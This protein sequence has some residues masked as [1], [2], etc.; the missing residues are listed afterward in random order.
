M[1]D[2]EKIQDIRKKAE[3]IIA[4]KYLNNKKL[5]EEE[6]EYLINELSI[7]QIELELQNEELMKLHNELNEA[8]AN[9]YD[10][11]ENAPVGYIKLN[12]DL[13]IIE[14][15]MTFANF[16]NST[17]EALLGKEFSKFIAPESQDSF[18]FHYD[19]VKKNKNFKNITE[20]TVLSSNNKRITFQADSIAKTDVNGNLYIKTVLTDVSSLKTIE[21]QLKLERN[22]YETL[23]ETVPVGIFTL[24]LDN[25]IL[26]WNKSAEKITGYTKDEVI[27]KKCSLC[28]LDISVCDFWDEVNKKISTK[29]KPII[30]KQGELRQISFNYSVIKDENGNPYVGIN[31]LVDITENLKNQEAINLLQIALNTTADNII[32]FDLD[33]LNIITV[34]QAFINDLGYSEDEIKNLTVADI[35]HK[36][37]DELKAFLKENL[38][39]LNKVFYFNDYHYR[40]DGTSFPVEIQLKS[41]YN[42]GKLYGIAVARDISNRLEYQTKINEQQ[43]F[44]NTIVENLPVGVFAK[45]PNDDFKFTIWNKKMEQLFGISAKEAIGKTDFDFFD[46]NKANFYYESD[47][48]TINSKKPTVFPELYFYI[49]DNVF[50]GRAVKIAIFDENDNPT[51]ILGI[52]EDITAIK[53]NEKMLEESERKFRLIAENAKDIIY[54]VVIM[55]NE[56]KFDYVSPS[57]YEITGYTPEDIYENY[58]LGINLLTSYDLMYDSHLVLQDLENYFQKDTIFS[59][60][61]KNKKQIWLETR[62]SIF[63]KD[64]VIEIEGV[65]RDVSNFI[66][67][68][69]FNRSLSTIFEMIAQNEDIEN[70]MMK[71]VE[72][73][74]KFLDTVYCLIV[75]MGDK[76]NTF[77]YFNSGK[78]KIEAN[79]LIKLIEKQSNLDANIE[80]I[81]FVKIN[82]NDVLWA[83]HNN[84]IGEEKQIE[85]IVIFY[86]EYEIL[87]KERM[88]EI[89]KITSNIA[90]IALEKKKF[91]QNLVE[92]KE[93]AEEASRLKSEFLANMSH[94]IRTPLNSILGFTDLMK[95]EITS[96]KKIMDYLKGIENAGKNLLNLINDI[97]DLSKIEAGKIS[98]RFKETNIRQLIN[99]IASIFQSKLIEKSLDFRIIIPDDFPNYVIFDELRLKQILLNLISNAV[100]FTAKGYIE[101][102]ISFNQNIDN[103]KIDFDIDI[104]D[105]GIGIPE[106]DYEI[107]FEP[108]HQRESMNTRNYE[109]TGL[110]LAITKKLVLLLGGQ[111]SVTSE[112][113]K[114]SKFSINFY[115]VDY[116]EKYEETEKIS[117]IEDIFF[118]KAKILVCEDNQANALVIKNYL[119]HY[120]F[121]LIFAL[122]GQQVLEYAEKEKPDLILMDLQIPKIDGIEATKILRSKKE[123]AKIPIVATTAL[124]ENL[125]EQETLQMFTDYLTKPLKKENVIKTLMKYIPYSRV[126]KECSSDYIDKIFESAGNDEITDEDLLNLTIGNFYNEWVNATRYLIINQIKKFAE[127]LLNFSNEKNISSLKLYSEKLLE[128]IEMFNIEGINFLLSKYTNII[129]KLRK[130]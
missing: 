103:K 71:L 17:K 18:Y 19:I 42:G 45:N 39:D 40:K 83:A 85:G 34:N 112:V 107:I 33:T 126:N 48:E 66:E 129:Q 20:L 38:K 54:K 32:L 78:S 104:I 117:S 62:N 101:F 100:K 1:L 80:G 31:T 12:S 61:S 109:G 127:K 94:E 79:K 21:N 58:Q 23:F 72:T 8:L 53:L 6:I 116:V 124:T 93:K 73:I 29:I 49:D 108:F 111:I 89:I 84:I 90:G 115:D 10:L 105:T 92:A 44:L 4:Q 75:F 120:N 119:N 81:S 27:G 60:Q 56:I 16:V 98:I 122:D 97:L 55:N 35:K 99:E 96:N 121:E 13:K 5:S 87:D 59:V 123:T 15:N 91:L 7:H 37:P 43:K 50:V 25:R 130:K 77:K 9:Y 26:S 76:T 14:T 106:S 2:Q 52:I 3:Q 64:D 70:T 63:Q 125:I 118:Q 51:T 30:T 65:A 86:S 41:F 95:E 28:F 110:G 74:E 68:L 88:T 57:I 11:Y 102:R 114:G 46:E 22:R 69:H 36:K 67:L 47:L 128:H 82:E 24:S 113:G